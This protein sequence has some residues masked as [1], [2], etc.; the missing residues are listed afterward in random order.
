MD[1]TGE[2]D[3]IGDGDGEASG[4]QYTRNPRQGSEGDALGE[5]EGTGELEAGLFSVPQ[6]QLLKSESDREGK[7][8]LLWAHRRP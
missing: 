3:A 1:A 5:A 2:G 6:E 4:G 8:P 7:L